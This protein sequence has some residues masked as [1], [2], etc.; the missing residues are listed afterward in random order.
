MTIPTTEEIQAAH[1]EVDVEG[2]A[3]ETTIALAQLALTDPHL[4]A[5]VDGV[6]GAAPDLIT[7]SAVMGALIGGLNLGIRIGEA[8]PPAEF[9][10]DEELT[11]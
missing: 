2:P 7:R 4:K 11:G 9:V 5:F 10:E 8:R 3:S 6:C 1:D